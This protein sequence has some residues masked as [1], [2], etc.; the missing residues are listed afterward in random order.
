[1]YIIMLSH[2]PNTQGGRGAPGAAALDPDR[3]LQVEGVGALS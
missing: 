1:M 3:P 2:L